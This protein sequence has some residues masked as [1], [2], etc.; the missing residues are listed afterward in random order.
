M[1]NTARSNR[2]RGSLGARMDPARQF[3]HTVPNV[4]GVDLA[5]VEDRAASTEFSA[6]VLGQSPSE[7]YPR[8]VIIQQSPVA[9]WH[10]GEERVVR[11]TASEGLVTPDVIG[12]TRGG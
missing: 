6:R 4:I 9:V 8:S 7:Q 1:T 3:A 10:M 12:Q 5:T 2:R 11:V